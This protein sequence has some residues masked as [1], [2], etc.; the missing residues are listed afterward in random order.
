[1]SAIFFWYS[2]KGKDDKEEKTSSSCRICGGKTVRDET[3]GLYRC[4]K[5][6]VFLM[7]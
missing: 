5:C 6:R 2:P 4:D 7:S 1:M 3:T